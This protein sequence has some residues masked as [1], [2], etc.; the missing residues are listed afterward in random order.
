MF[1]S[2]GMLFE[3]SVEWSSPEFKGFVRF[4]RRTLNFDACLSLKLTECLHLEF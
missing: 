4:L 3:G 1:A 2:E